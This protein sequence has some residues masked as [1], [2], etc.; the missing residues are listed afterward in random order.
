MP[1]SLETTCLPDNDRLLHGAQTFEI[2]SLES[3]TL[4]YLN[5]VVK[6]KTELSMFWFSTVISVRNVNGI[7]N[8]RRVYKVICTIWLKNK[9]SMYFSWKITSVES[10]QNY[11]CGI[12]TKCFWTY[13]QSISSISIVLW[14]M[15]LKLIHILFSWME[16]DIFIPVFNEIYQFLHVIK[17]LKLYAAFLLLYIPKANSI[18]TLYTPTTD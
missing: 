13:M 4:F 17:F 8:I 5:E 15:L 12:K 14:S 7:W 6:S 3:P 1:S 2:N 18:M 11:I 10:R 16:F 9:I